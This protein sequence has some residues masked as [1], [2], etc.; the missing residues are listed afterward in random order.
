LDA[1]GAVL[2]LI[3][4]PLRRE[5]KKALVCEAPP[6][7][8]AQAGLDVIGEALVG[9]GV[10]VQHGLAGDLVHVL[11]AG[12]ARAHELPRQLVV[13]E[14]PTLVDFDH[15][16]STTEH[17]ENAEKKTRARPCRFC[18]SSVFSVCSVV[19]IKSC[20]QRDLPEVR[21]ALHVLQRLGNL[22]EA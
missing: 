22:P 4:K 5:D 10:P 6:L 8:S 12:A 20:P 19:P 3:A 15:G 18:L 13:G 7:Q 16:I 9:G 2:V 14:A 17:T 21:P 1:V 11:P